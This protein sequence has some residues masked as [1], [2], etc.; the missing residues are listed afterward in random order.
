MNS[1]CPSSVLIM[2]VIL[3]L[4]PQLTSRFN[5]ERYLVQWRTVPSS[6]MD[7]WNTAG[8]ARHQ[9]IIISQALQGAGR[10]DVQHQCRLK[11]VATWLP[12][13]G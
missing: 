10:S 12:T 2:L 9:S 5:V 6:P 7:N 13:Q 8:C 4:V 11:Q 3:Q 1:N